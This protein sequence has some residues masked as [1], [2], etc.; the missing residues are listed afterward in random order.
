MAAGIDCA[1]AASATERT[2]CGDSE[3]RTL[4]ASIASDFADALAA[5]QGG[6]RQALL[7][8]QRSWL[9]QRD[10]ECRSDDA[11]CLRSSYQARHDALEALTARISPG[12]P[13]LS[14]A[15][16]VAL[17]G[18]WKIENDLVPSAP[19]QPVASTDMPAELP[20]QGSTIIGRPGKLCFASGECLPF[21]LDRQKLDDAASLHLP[22]STPLYVA[23]LS[24]KAVY[25]LIQRADGSLLARFQICDKTYTSCTDAFQVW[26]PA[27]PDAGVRVLAN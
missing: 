10:Q 26:K 20:K 18:R 12:N 5:T 27:S 22:P 25:G 7:A 16:A 21:G 9:R 19:G 17:L 15:T 2:I 11:A 14:D 3:L 24:G 23:Y 8:Q 4:D 1:K 13:T 6:T